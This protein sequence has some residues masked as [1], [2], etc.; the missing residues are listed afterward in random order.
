MVK[1]NKMLT[2]STFKTI[3]YMVIS[4]FL[5][6]A[7]SHAESL[8]IP[9]DQ[10]YIQEADKSF[11]VYIGKELTEDGYTLL[12]GFGHEPSSHWLE[13]VPAQ[14]H[15][16]DAEITVG[17]TDEARLPGKLTK[18]PQVAHT[19]RYITSNY[20]EFAGFP[21]PLTNGGLNE[22]GV[23]GRDVWSSSRPELVE[24]TP[25]EQ[26]G[27]Q[28]S[29]LSRIAME[30]ASSAREAVEILGA[31]I[32]AYG[33]STY[34]GNSHLF[35]DSNEGWVFIEM[36]GGQG[37]WAAERLSSNEIRVSYPGYIHDFP[38]EAIEN[39][40]ENYLGSN[41]LISFA[42]EQGWYDP[43]TDDTFNIQNVYQVPFPTEPFDVGE[44]ASKDDP[45]PYRNPISLEEEFNTLNNIKLE[46]VMRIVRDPRWSDDRAGYGQ[47]AQLRDD[48]NYAENQTLWVAT[49]AAITAPYLPIAIGTTHLPIEY[50]Q[51]RYLTAKASST[52]LDPEYAAQEATESATQIFKRLMYATHVNPKKNLKKV[53][54]AFEGFEADLIINWQKLIEEAEKSGNSNTLTDYT[55]AAA[56]N[57]LKLGYLLL[58]ELVTEILAEESFH[59]PKV[60]KDSG[61]TAST[62]SKPMNLRSRYTS[63]DRVNL[64]LGGGWAEG[65][66]TERAGK[67]GDPAKVPDY[68]S[69]KLIGHPID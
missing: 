66:A 18:I 69:V 27:P 36:A 6:G 1:N 51:H 65:S 12:G 33:F 50:S 63:R 61:E 5:V 13:I 10:S 23:A 40:H 46:D 58:D 49:T 16:A 30:R 14:N 59:E 4:S 8:H 68:S 67:Y 25:S 44:V 7:L 28:Y 39:N 55:N 41:N 54:D 24:M 17:V 21:A 37:L 56:I 11:A 47:V 38:I 26:T 35:A 2:L 52:F 29:D 34:G 3:S 53:T 64:D 57:G 31:L 60:E 22:K 20:S 48:L 15:T 9:D 43:D 45:S 62:H 32:D 19:Y 42:L